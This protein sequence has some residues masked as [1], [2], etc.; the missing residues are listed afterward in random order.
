MKQQTWML[1]V[2][3]IAALGILSLHIV[4]R[5]GQQWSSDQMHALRDDFDRLMKTVIEQAAQE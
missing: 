2:P 3:P 4:S 5:V 1:V